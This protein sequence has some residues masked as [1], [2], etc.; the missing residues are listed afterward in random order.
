MVINKSRIPAQDCLKSV[1]TKDIIYYELYT[2]EEKVIV[3]PELPFGIMSRNGGPHHFYSLW[4][5]SY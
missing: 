2:H 1:K 5:P 4:S 3:K